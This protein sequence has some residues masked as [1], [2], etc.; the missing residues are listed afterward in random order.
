MARPSRIYLDTCA[1]M[2][3]FDGRSQT[4]I[5][6]E[7]SAIETFFRFPQKGKVQ[8]V[9][10]E[11]LEAEILGNPDRKARARV[12]RLLSGATERIILSDAAFLRAGRLERLGYGALHLACAEDTAADALLTT[13]DR[14]LRRA[15]HGLGHPE[16]AVENSVNWL[17]RFKP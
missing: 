16:I 11:V 2:R 17:Q 7:A 6:I 1:L 5:D 4:R 15:R 3:L 12:S 8:W 9:A 14:F 13:D 10:G